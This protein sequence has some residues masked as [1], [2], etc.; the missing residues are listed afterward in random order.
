MDKTAMAWS[1]A[2]ANAG[3]GRGRSAILAVVAACA[4]ALPAYASDAPTSVTIGSGTMAYSDLV[5]GPAT[6]MMRTLTIPPNEDLP[7]HYHP[8]AGA[9]TIVVRGTLV[10]EDGCGGEAVYT[11]GQAFLEPPFRV[12]RGRNLT[13]AEVVTAQTFVV[14][15][16][17]PTTV[18][19][20][21]QRMCGVP[22]DIA[23]CKS[24]GWMAFDLPRA[25]VSQGDCEQF[26]ITGK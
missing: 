5:G 17:L 20:G 13:D 18:Q 6:V 22:M 26:V 11:Q 4:I 1:K 24:S 8:G 14:P 12:H 15:K 7:W 2:S 10:V 16:G 3:L 21:G 23:E 9:Q 25:F 19:T